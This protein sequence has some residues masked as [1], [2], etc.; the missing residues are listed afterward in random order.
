MSGLPPE[1]AH[2]K[3]NLNLH[4]T[5]R[6]GEYHTLDSL[7][8][9]ADAA[10]RLTA[11]PADRLTL[12]IVG[13]FAAQLRG[14]DPRENLVVRA[15]SALAGAS[16]VHEGA[17]L[18]LEK[19]LPV[20]S[21]IGGGS[22]DAAASLRLLRRLWRIKSPISDELAISLGADVPVCLRSTPVVMRGIGEVLHPAP[23]LPPTGLVMVNPLVPVA[24]GAVFRARAPGFSEP[25]RLAAS[26]NTAAELASDLA[27]SRNDLQ[28]PAIAIAPV[29]AEVLAALERQHGCLLARMSGSGATCFALF[30]PGP[31][32]AAACRAL[33]EAGWWLWH[34][35]LVPAYAA[36]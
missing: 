34:G 26:W 30:E 15:A 2:A 35:S 27:R 8:V 33:S 9:F 11:E 29:I 1:P 10:D 13:P 28:G 22:A 23:V 14:L 21:G 18:R 24:T 16:N 20:A 19:R 3:I 32:A 5:G 12:E 17:A 36:P 6:R 7:V 31:D 25:V 4:V